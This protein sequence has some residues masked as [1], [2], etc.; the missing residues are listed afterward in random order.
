MLPSGVA[1]R[2]WMSGAEI[3]HVDLRA[4]LAERERALDDVLELPDVAGPGIRHQPAQRVLRHRHVRGGTCSAP[5][6]SRKCCTSSGMSSRRSR[7]GGSCTGI[8]LRR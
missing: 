4:S 3:G 2:F 7:S 1:G 5:S 8:T 6:F